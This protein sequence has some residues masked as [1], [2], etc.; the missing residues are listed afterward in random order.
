MPQGDTEAD[1]YRCGA[2]CGLGR[3]VQER[4]YQII[5]ARIREVSCANYADGSDKN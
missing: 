1:E 5:T 3:A 2:V 4:I